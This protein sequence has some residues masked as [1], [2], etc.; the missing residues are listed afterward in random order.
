MVFLTVLFEV[1]GRGLGVQASVTM[2]DC[3][4]ET[5]IVWGPK[6]S[7]VSAAL[8]HHFYLIHGCGYVVVAPPVRLQ[9]PYDHGFRIES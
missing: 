6:A 5:F 2:N 7:N 4:A 8:G 3:D 1:S 9:D